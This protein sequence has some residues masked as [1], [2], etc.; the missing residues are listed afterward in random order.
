MAKKRTIKRDVGYLSVSPT[1]FVYRVVVEPDGNRYY[2]E[3]P[4]LKGCYSW[5]RTYA[6]ALRNIK[7]ALEL[8]LEVKREDGEP[9]PIENP[10]TVRRA[11]LSIGVLV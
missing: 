4:A 5:G 8:W 2:A 6:E 10:R 1:P 3:I 11:P 7:E 9:I